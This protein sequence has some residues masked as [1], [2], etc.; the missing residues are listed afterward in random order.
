[1]EFS[2]SEYYCVLFA[3]MV[4]STRTATTITN[5]EKMRA[6]YGIFINSLSAVAKT[7]D[8]N[9]IKTAGDGIICY[10]P[11]TANPHSRSCFKK[12]LEC[13]LEMICA[14]PKINAKM[15]MEGLPSISY[16]ISADYGNH[17]IVTSPYS[18]ISDLF[19]TTMNICSKINTLASPN[20]MVIGGDLFEIVKSY[21]EFSFRTTGEYLAGLRNAYPVYMVLR[22][23]DDSIG[24]G[25]ALLHKST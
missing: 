20:S 6:F 17:E 11:E 25:L 3:D 1:M 18:D 7:F 14:H 23:A 10:F 21:H 5:S 24:Q 12:V 4:N 15:R 16:R 8:S 19:G 9:V 13:G 2:G 22:T